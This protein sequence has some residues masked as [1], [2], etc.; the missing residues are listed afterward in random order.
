M[1]TERHAWVSARTT[2]VEPRTTSSVCGCGQDLDVCAGAHC[3]RCGTRFARPRAAVAWHP[4]ALRVD[5]AD[6]T[7]HTA[8]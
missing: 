7:R 3:P 5:A 8:A 1:T 4:T 2:A 6:W